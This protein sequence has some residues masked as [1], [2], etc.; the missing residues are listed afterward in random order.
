MKVAKK[1]SM[2]V[3][4]IFGLSLIVGLVFLIVPFTSKNPD[5]LEKVSQT[6][7]FLKKDDS[8][9][10]LNAPMP[11]YSMSGI[12]SKIGS[13]QYAS[14]IGVFVV[15]GTTVFVGYMLKRKRDKM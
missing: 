8:K 13:R 11:E 5:G 6:M 7:G 9:P 15:F 14:I 2:L 4:I 10:L 3:F 1:Q 12:K